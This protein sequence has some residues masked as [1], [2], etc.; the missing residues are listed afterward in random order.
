[1]VVVILAEKPSQEK[2]YQ[3]EKTSITLKACK[4]FPE[5]AIITLGIGHLVSLKMPNEYKEEWGKWDLKNLPIV[6]DEF[7]FKVVSDKKTQFSFIKK[8]F[9]YPAVSS[10]V[11]A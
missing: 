1:M 4:T 9:N 10:I 6:P 5:G 2:A 7:Q 11:K 8:L 3:V